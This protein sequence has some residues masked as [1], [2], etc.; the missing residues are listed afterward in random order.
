VA[1]L[2]SIFRTDRG[3]MH[4][5][6]SP[7]FGPAAGD[8]ESLAS[9]LPALFE[10]AAGFP[11]SDCPVRSLDPTTLKTTSL[12]AGAVRARKTTPHRP[13]GG[14]TAAALTIPDKFL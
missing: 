7:T 9:W 11:N 8:R 13:S 12:L 4:K 1:A 2:A 14:G 3:L 6:P 5:G 10:L